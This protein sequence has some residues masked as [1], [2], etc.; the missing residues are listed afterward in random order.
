M[1][2]DGKARLETDKY[3]ISYIDGI[4]SEGGDATFTVNAPESGTYR[5]TLNYA[6]NLEGGYHAY[7]VDL[8]E[9]LLT[10]S[11]NGQA[12]DIFCR[13]TYSLYTYKTLTFS[14]EL[15]KGE[16]TVRL[17]S[18]GNIRFNGNETLAPRIE[19]VTINK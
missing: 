14:L 7:N 6:N 4:S 9:A 19:S 10:V 13:N 11:A 5:V 12:Q 15:N 16:N 3:G 18:S 2:L 1:N 17:S 8:I